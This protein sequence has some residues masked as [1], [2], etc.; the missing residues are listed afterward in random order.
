MPILVLI[1][2]MKW[3]SQGLDAHCMEV[4]ILQRMLNMGY[5]SFQLIQYACRKS[6][7]EV[8]QFPH[9]SYDDG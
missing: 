1:Y 8:P 6:A 5:D 2:T 3:Y 9:A 4:N 7:P